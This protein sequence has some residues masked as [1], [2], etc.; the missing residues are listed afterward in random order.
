MI[1]VAIEYKPLG[2]LRKRRINTSLPVRWSEMTPIQIAAIPRLHRGELDD[3]K[4]LQIFLGVK[5]SIARHI[6]HFQSYYILRNLKYIKEA[7][8]IAKF[9]VKDI[10]GFKAPDDKLKDVTFGAFIFGD[11]Y[12][13]NYIGG[14]KEDLDKF[15]A[16]FYCNE[17]GFSEK[18]IETNA[19][20]IAL[21]DISVR[22]AIAI[23]YGLV[24][25]WLAKAYPFV[26]QKSVSGKKRAKNSGWV[27]VFDRLVQNDLANQDKYSQLPVSTVLRNLNI[28]MEDYIKNGGKV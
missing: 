9:V 27:A 11:T 20:I 14:K 13:Q 16:S 22:E 18:D 6:D 21:A 19:A 5:K 7:E 23:N 3:R 1:S 28:K 10:Q 25:E 17:K 26:F 2:F 24:R 12:F 8:P 4:I 15:I